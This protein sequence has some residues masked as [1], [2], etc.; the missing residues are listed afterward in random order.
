[1]TARRLVI[2]PDRIDPRRLGEAVERLHR[3]EVVA[4]PTDTFYAIGCALEAREAIG[5]IYRLKRMEKSQRLSLICPD[6][7]TAAV[8]ASISRDAFLLARRLLPGPFTLILPATREVPRT[9]MDKRRRQVGIRIPDHDV[10]RALVAALGRPLLT[11]SAT[12]PDG[13]PCSH[14]DDVVDGF[15]RGLELVIDAGPTSGE[16]STVIEVDD[17][18]YHVVRQGR[19]IVAPS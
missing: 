5:Q 11:T 14:A 16:P 4:Y 19:G 17:Q 6:I 10:C 13:E 7:S 9:L 15:P 12:P 1:V 2:D 18:G 3:G 8:Y